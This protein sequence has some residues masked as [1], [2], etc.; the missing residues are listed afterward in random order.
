M[1]ASMP[2]RRHPCRRSTFRASSYLCGSWD[3]IHVRVTVGN[4][5]YGI[6]GIWLSIGCT[7]ASSACTLARVRF[8]SKIGCITACNSSQGD[9]SKLSNLK[10]A[11]ENT[12]IYGLTQTS[13]PV[14]QVTRRLSPVN[15][16]GGLHQMHSG[17]SNLIGF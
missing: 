12:K 16:A 13:S 2:Y 6:Y 4:A 7:R 3:S 8:G 14:R 9:L 10:R 15:H 11:Q 1:D 5:I 17:I